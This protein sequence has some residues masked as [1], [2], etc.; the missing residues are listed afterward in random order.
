MTLRALIA[1]SFLVVAGLCRAQGSAFTTGDGLSQDSSQ[2]V[3]Q[4][5]L[6]ARTLTQ[7]GAAGSINNNPVTLLNGLAFRSDGNLYAVA[8]VNGSSPLLV[9]LSRTLGKASL[10]SQI[11]GVPS[12]SGSSLS[13]AF[14][15]DDHLW[16]ASSDSGN[17]W[18]LTPGTGQ[19]RAIGNLGAKI[20]RKSVV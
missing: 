9:T 14:S 11:N 16:M 13:L 18:E 20:D 10:V 15:C 2:V 4:L 1:A 19:T 12:T 5:N 3:Y 6:G 17:L 8:Q 7:V